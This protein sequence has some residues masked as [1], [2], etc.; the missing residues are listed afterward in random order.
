MATDGIRYSF[1]HDGISVLIILFA[2]VGMFGYSFRAILPVIA[3]DV[4]HGG[5][6]ILSYLATAV[7]IGAVSGTL[8]VTF[9]RKFSSRVFII[10]GV[11]CMGISLSIFPFAE[12]LTATLILFFFAG[13]GFTMVTTMVRSTAQI[14]VASHMKGRMMG[15]LIMSF[16]AGIAIGSFLTGLAAKRFGAVNATQVNGIILFLFGI[17][18]LI[19]KSKIPLAVREPVAA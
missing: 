15:I 9:L 3:G 2:F 13:A 10:F 14:I 1:L 5:A 19:W 17:T 8:A 6:D 7:G 4:F 16:F 11:L 12:K 18:L